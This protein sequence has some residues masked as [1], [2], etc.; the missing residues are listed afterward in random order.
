M[1]N[2]KELPGL[3]LQLLADTALG[4]SCVFQICRPVPC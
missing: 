2:L 4:D 1:F 3:S